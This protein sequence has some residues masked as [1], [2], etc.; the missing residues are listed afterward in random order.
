VAALALV[1]TGDG[2]LRIQ[3][4]E[5]AGEVRAISRPLIESG[6]IVDWRRGWLD[7]FD[8]ARRVEAEAEASQASGTHTDE[9]LEADEE[10]TQLAEL[11]LEAFQAEIAP[12]AASPDELPSVLGSYDGEGGV[13]VAATEIDLSE[14]EMP[15]G[16]T[17]RELHELLRETSRRRAVFVFRWRPIEA[18][19]E[20]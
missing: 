16:P 20:G 13:N 1:R 2:D 14:A 8:A 12:Q 19:G 15:L 4:W 11:T 5:A 10:I 18:L 7:G 9:V 17:L 6:Q 3:A